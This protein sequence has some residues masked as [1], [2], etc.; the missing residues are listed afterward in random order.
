MS[1]QVRGWRGWRGGE[2]GEGKFI[3]EKATI[4]YEAPISIHGRFPGKQS[5]LTGI[6]F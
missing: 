6:S 4:I 2:N 5:R 1:L 3:E